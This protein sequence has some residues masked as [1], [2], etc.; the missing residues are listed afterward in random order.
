MA[1]VTKLMPLLVTMRSLCDAMLIELAYEQKV[2][3]A[4]GDD[5][6]SGAAHAHVVEPG[7]GRTGI[8]AICGETV[9]REVKNG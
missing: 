9:A 7:L 8:C 5:R 6:R 2:R 3:A 4:E 1:D